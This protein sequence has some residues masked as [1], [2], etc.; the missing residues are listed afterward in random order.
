MDYINARLTGRVGATQSPFGQLVCDNRT[1]G[2][3]EYDPE[4][5][6]ATELDP[7]KLATLL[8]MNGIVGTVTS[9]VAAELGIAEGT[10]VTTGT[11]D[12]ITSAIGAGALTARDASIIVGTTS[13]LVTHIDHYRGD[14]R[15]GLLA[16]PS[17]LIGQYFVMAENGVGGRALE[18]TMRLFGYGDDYE[19]D[20][21]CGVDQR[22]RRRGAVRT[23]VAGFRCPATRRRCPRRLHR[24]FSST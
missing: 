24:S 18:W 11:I 14:L 5:V 3:T 13:V 12:S 22:W 17:P 1:W 19:C 10:P 20:R 8:P 23:V 6:A 9:T 16:V 2:L 4:L 15:S 7:D 21:R